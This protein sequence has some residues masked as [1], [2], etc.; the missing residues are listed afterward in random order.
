MSLKFA[1][2]S[3]HAGFRLKNFLMEYLQKNNIEYLDF[4]V[5]SADSVD[6]PNYAKL[7]CESIQRG[8]C[9]RGLLVCGSG[10][11][12]SMSA[13]K[14][15]GIRCALIHDSYGAKMCR[16]HNNANVI[17][18]GERVT[19]TGVAVEALELFIKT[20]FLINVENHVRRVAIMDS[21]IPK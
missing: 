13:N 11:G 3:D 16:E 9:N 20:D 21:F 8:E 19:G 15:A 6:Y 4:G 7:A 17:A 14:F 1:V 2:A 5:N 12:I 10:I 18:F